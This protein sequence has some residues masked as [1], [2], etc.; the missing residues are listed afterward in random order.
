MEALEVETVETPKA[1]G[2]DAVEAGAPNTEVAEVETGPPK[3]D[4]VEVAG[5]GAPKTVEV[6]VVDPNKDDEEMGASKTGFDSVVEEASVE[7]GIE[8]ALVD[9]TNEGEA[10]TVVALETGA[11]PPNTA[12]AGPPKTV[13]TDTEVVDA[14]V[15]TAVVVTEV[16]SE[17]ATE[18]VTAAGFVGEEAPNKLREAVFEEAGPKIEEPEGE[19]APKLLAPDAGVP[20][21]LHSSGLGLSGVFSSAED[22]AAAAVDAVEADSGIEAVVTG[23]DSVL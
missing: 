4:D 22:A 8:E 14:V 11:G 5:F 20:S 6:E 10:V 9:A 21:F 16:L 1:V 23:S 7:M 18:V 12:G 2:V 15:A 13:G 3:T 19:V 17:D